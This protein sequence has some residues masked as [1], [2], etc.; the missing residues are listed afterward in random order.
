LYTSTNIISGEVK[1]DDMGGTC[2]MHG[3][4]V[5]C[6]QDFG[7]GPEGERPLGRPR[8]RWEDKI[9]MHLREIGIDGANWILLAQDK[10]QWR[11][12]LITLTKLRVL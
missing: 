1:E 10:V 9:K 12:F 5:K 11:A 3:G 2:S 7:W 4:R 6:L 8:C